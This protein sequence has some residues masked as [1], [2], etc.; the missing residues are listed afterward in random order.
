[1]SKV[2]IIKDS[3]FAERRL[4]KIE[5]QMNTKYPCTNI[6][7]SATS[8]TFTIYEAQTLVATVTPSYTTQNVRWS[9]EDETI[10]TVE[11]GVVTPLKKG[12]TTIT[13]T[14]GSKSASCTVDVAVENYV[15]LAQYSYVTGTTSA[16]E[17]NTARMIGY[18]TIPTVKLPTSADYGIDFYPIVI[19][20]GSTKIVVYMNGLR[21]GAQFFQVKDGSITWMSEVTT[22]KVN[23]DVG[24]RVIDVPAGVNGVILNLRQGSSSSTEVSAD[25]DTSEFSVTFV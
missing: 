14:C 12:S 15:F 11:N 10:A 9:S 8:L 22:S 13:V 7:L 20:D 25:Y 2:L 5:I 3:D 24:Y 19:P 18:G 16:V 21:C 1:M 23:N 17:A 6:R 4:E